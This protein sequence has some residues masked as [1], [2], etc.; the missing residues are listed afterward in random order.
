MT[1][2][3]KFQMNA[4]GCLLFMKGSFHLRRK[5]K[6]IILHKEPFRGPSPL[7]AAVVGRK[8]LLHFLYVSIICLDLYAMSYISSNRHYRNY[9]ITS[10]ENK[11]ACTLIAKAR[12]HLQNTRSAS[13]TLST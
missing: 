7:K 6:C 11:S 1:V 2:K 12:E 4:L 5:T 10:F 3:S 9:G 13:H 8:Q